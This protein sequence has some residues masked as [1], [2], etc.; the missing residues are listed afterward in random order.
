MLKLMGELLKRNV[1]VE[2]AEVLQKKIK[3]IKNVYWQELTKIE[4]SKKKW[5]RS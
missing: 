3:S 1:A 5:S 2:S 4:K